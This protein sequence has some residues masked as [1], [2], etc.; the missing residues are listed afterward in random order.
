MEGRDKCGH[1]CNA[2]VFMRSIRD[3]SNEDSTP[4]F[5]AIK[6]TALGPPN[7]LERMSTELVRL[8]G[9]LDRG[10]SSSDIRGA[11]APVL[12]PEELVMFDSMLARLHTLASAVHAK[13]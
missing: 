11:L 3:A 12:M 8:G 2:R 10:H 5:M 6:V 13:V 9:G 4:G 1:E 7:L